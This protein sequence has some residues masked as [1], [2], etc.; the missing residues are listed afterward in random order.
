MLD[1]PVAFGTVDH[2]LHRLRNDFGVTAHRWHISYFSNRSYMAFMSGSYSDTLYLDFGVPQ[3]SVTGPLCFLYYTHV[4]GWILR[5][6]NVTNHIYADDIKVYLTSDSSIT[7]D[8]QCAFLKLSR[9]FAGIQHW[10]VENKNKLNPDKTLF[11]LL[12]LHKIKKINVEQ[13]QPPSWQRWSF[14]T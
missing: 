10:M 13:Y 1:L 7:G 11:F 14:S 5:V 3:G 4:V 2:E 9:C 8:I 12:G 6:H